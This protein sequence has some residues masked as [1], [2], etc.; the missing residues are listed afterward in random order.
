MMP[1]VLQP[2]HSGIADTST[3]AVLGMLGHVESRLPGLRQLLS[4]S[5]DVF[6]LYLGFLD[7]CRIPMS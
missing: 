2:T 4:V 7:P 1:E 3:E 6:F 5:L